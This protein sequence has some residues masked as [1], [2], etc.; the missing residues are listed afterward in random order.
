VARDRHPEHGKDSVDQDKKPDGTTQHVTGEQGKIIIV[1][2][3]KPSLLF[4]TKIPSLT[5]DSEQHLTV[6]ANKWH[7]FQ[8]LKLSMC[9]RFCRYG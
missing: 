9:G 1:K 2:N 5:G 7:W 6:R 3:L 4:G 8:A